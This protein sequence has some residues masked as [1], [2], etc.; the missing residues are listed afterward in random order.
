MKGALG[1]LN[2]IGGRSSFVLA[3]LRQEQTLLARRK[4]DI[5]TGLKDLL[6]GQEAKA[7]SD[8]LRTSVAS[9]NLG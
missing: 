6:F 9:L 5:Q 4:H 8:P 7:V 3:A 1:A 2:R